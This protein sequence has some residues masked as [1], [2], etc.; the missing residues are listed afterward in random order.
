MADAVSPTLIV[1]A[2]SA[3]LTRDRVERA[4]AIL[5]R[6]S[7]RQCHILDRTQI[8]G[9][10]VERLDVVTEILGQVLS[11]SE[12]AEVA[13]YLAKRALVALP[14]IVNVSPPARVRAGVPFRIQVDVQWA[15]ASHPRA[16]LW[17]RSRADE[18]D[19][20]TVTLI[21]PLGAE[22]SGGVSLIPETASRAPFSA[23]RILELST[24]TVGQVALGELVVGLSGSEATCVVDLGVLGVV[25]NMRPRFFDR[26]Y[27]EGLARLAESYDRATTGAT[28]SVGVVGVGGSGKSRLCDEFALEK[29]R[30]GCRVVSVRHP[31]THEE[32][33]R[34]LADLL[35]G[36]AGDDMATDEPAEGVLRAVAQYDSALSE[37]VAPDV[38]SLFGTRTTAAVETAEQHVVSTRR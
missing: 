25:E 35:V 19:A 29:R 38:R 17:W 9:L 22:V 1:V 26:P 16:R 7:L 3:R 11:E 4:R 27:A 28:C 32:P 18:P 6:Q 2:L 33:L 10:M 34:I 12:L 30:R 14:P 36:L 24:Y 8:E 23:T 37:R 5:Q 13:A 31:K 21:G 20:E 15:L